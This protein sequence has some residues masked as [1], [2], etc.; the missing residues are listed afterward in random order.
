MI[1]KSKLSLESVIK[2]PM[3]FAENLCFAMSLMFLIPPIESVIGEP[4]SYAPK[5]IV[6]V[7]F[8]IVNRCLVVLRRGESLSSV[9][10]QVLSFVLFAF[11]LHEQVGLF[12]ILR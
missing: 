2:C 12:P 8:F 1:N 11:A 4:V 7:L 5:V 6:G 10:F 9:V 3:W